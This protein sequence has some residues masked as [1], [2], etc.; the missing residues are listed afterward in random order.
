MVWGA[1]EAGT[2]ARGLWLDPPPPAPPPPPHRW[3]QF[4]E[5]YKSVTL[6]RMAAAFAVSP[7][8]M[9]EELAEFIVRGQV[10]A[11]IDRVAGVVQTTR[12]RGRGF[13]CR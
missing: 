11:R 6:E 8:F 13:A 9:D 12:Y 10:A 1:A 7:G 5:S 2:A 4:L 3:P